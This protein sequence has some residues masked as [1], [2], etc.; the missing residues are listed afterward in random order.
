MGSGSREVQEQA[1]G[2]TQVVADW[3][4]AIE[5]SRNRPRVKHRWL[6]IQW[7]QSRQIARHWLGRHNNLA[8]RKCRDKAFIGSLWEEQ[9]VQGSMQSRHK[10]GMFNGSDGFV[11]QIR[12]GAVQHPR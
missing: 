10:A 8:K 1:E 5:K 7:Q 6:Q 11:Q 9:G 4:Q 2:Q 3:D 12:Q